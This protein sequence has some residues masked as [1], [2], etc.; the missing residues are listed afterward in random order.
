MLSCWNKT[1]G[2]LHLQMIVVVI[3]VVVVVGMAMVMVVVM[4]STVSWRLRMQ[5]CLVV[6]D[7]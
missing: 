1:V 2:G 7:K 6:N 5:S 3:V 4:G